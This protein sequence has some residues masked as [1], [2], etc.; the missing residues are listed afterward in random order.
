MAREPG[1]AAV[2]ILTLALGLG[3]NT[4]IF[5]IVNTVIL[6]PLAY[7]D[8][9]E[10]YVIR[11]VIP[12][13]SHLYPSIPV[14]A[15]HF[16][17]WKKEC[18]AFEDLAAV[19]PETYNLTGA[20]EPQRLFGARVTA[21]LFSL[22]GVQPQ[23]GRSFLPEEDQPG[24]DHVA[25]L[26]DTLWRTQF[27]AD[28]LLAGKTIT[29]DGN[30]YLVIGILPAWFRFPKNEQ[31]GALVK[32]GK[33]TDVFKP[34][35]FSKGEMESFGNFNFVVLGRMRAGWTEQ[36]ASAELNV[37][38][39]RQAS[40]APV[41]T[42]LRALIAPLDET[43]TGQARRGLLVL[44][45]AVGAVLLI[46]CVNLA[47]LLLARTAGRSRETAIRTALGASR[48]RLLR[49]V[50]S[51]TLLFSVLGGALGVALAVGGLQLMV[52]GAPVDLPRLDEVA[53]DARVLW[54]ALGI[55][56]LTGLLFGMLP[57]WKLARIDPHD[58]LK[59][60]SQ[61]TTEGGR[62][63][64]LRE[65]LIGLEVA[66]S[67]VLL[68]VAGLLMSSFVRLTGVDKGFDTER[69]AGV[70]LALP[71]AKYM[72]REKRQRF[73]DDTLARV[74]ELPG[75]VSAGLITSMPLNGENN[76]NM[77]TVEG[78]PKPIIER[79][80][81]NYRFISPE[82]FHTIG[83]PL[84]RGRLLAESDRGRNVALLS[85]RAAR[86]LWPQ[87]NPIGKR[88]HMGDEKQ[89]VVE[90]IGVVA[91]IRATTLQSDPVLMAYFPY[92]QRPPMSASVVVRTAGD[93]RALASGLR[94][95][96]WSVDPEVPVPELRTMERVL[97]DSVSQRR[98]QMTLVLAFAGAALLLASLGIYG[99]VSYSVARRTNEMGIRM[100]LGARS[101]DLHRLVV[102]QG[103]KPVLLG[104]AA[105]VAGALALGR[106]LRSL[107]FEVSA[108]DPV[109]IAG[110]VALLAAVAVVACV[111]PAVRATRVD[112]MVALRWE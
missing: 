63:L 76:V 46:V 14:N 42:D 106:V 97:S 110:V 56:T 79:P 12:K 86:R 35:A 68:I 105:G 43:V 16:L 17:A 58:A 21:N 96:I 102:I 36:R 67:A 48:G 94:A 81:A 61:R 5:S 74:R 65:G 24:R 18:S 87:A 83:I 90:V 2:A 62:G 85:E 4:A 55:S 77:L 89:P 19:N 28:P 69:V 108:T 37:V 50:L 99:V 60:G 8:P 54:F 82:Y 6:K 29:L 98:F 91:D 20:G 1:F 27:H 104:L 49:Q 51:E 107:L 11:E 23:L 73:F 47:N 30:A 93:P 44:Q 75:V 53:L 10:L 40:L 103:L 78:D 34:I 13:V 39:T 15:P 84:R 41:K 112:P 33:T 32:F 70:D 7:R 31:L 109:T 71:M 25:I 101:G 80:I 38:Q 26:T 95:K 45:A 66:L 72:Q 9:Q 92:W 57:A 111:I 100:A 22:L 52:R 64:R 59:A 88:I 3:A